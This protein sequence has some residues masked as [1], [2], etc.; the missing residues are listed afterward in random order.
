MKRMCKDLDQTLLGD[1]SLG[2]LILLVL[3]YQY[4]VS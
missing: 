4:T 1:S 3:I 2:K